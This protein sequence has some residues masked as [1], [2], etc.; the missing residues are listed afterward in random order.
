M[1]QEQ[2]VPLNSIH[3][4]FFFLPLDLYSVD[5]NTWVFIWFPFL[6][7]QGNSHLS[8][9]F[10]SI[11]DVYFR[12]R[13]CCTFL[14]LIC[15]ISTR[16]LIPWARLKLALLSAET[17]PNISR[18][19]WAIS[20]SPAG[21]VILCHL[22]RDIVKV[23]L[24]ITDVLLP[25]WRKTSGLQYQSH[26][27]SFAPASKQSAHLKSLENWAAVSTAKLILLHFLLLLVFARSN[28]HRSARK[29]YSHIRVPSQGLWRMVKLLVRAKPMCL[30]CLL[31]PGQT[32][33]DLPRCAMVTPSFYSGGI[34]SVTPG[35]TSSSMKDFWWNPLTG[36]LGFGMM[37][38]VLYQLLSTMEFL[39]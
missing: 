21:K 19:T 9:A 3:L 11:F 2:Q 30:R 17:A 12:M 1:Q 7:M 23:D 37:G 27:K 35:L 25:L 18:P 15:W 20:H 29:C 39:N 22:V 26:G 16:V 33:T 13:G 5:S 6:G 34:P 28:W 38:K 36:A 4:F 32:D 14:H 31:L 10:W 8:R 24:S